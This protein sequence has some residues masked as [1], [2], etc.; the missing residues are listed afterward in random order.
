MCSTS[1][2]GAVSWSN[3]AALRRAHAAPV[4]RG[5]GLDHA[6]GDEWVV[7]CVA[8]LDSATASASSHWSAAG[9]KGALHAWDTNATGAPDRPASPGLRARGARV[10]PRGAAPRGPWPVR[11]TDNIRSSSAASM[12]EDSGWLPRGVRA[13][14]PAPLCSPQVGAFGT[15]HIGGP[16]EFLHR[17]PH[18]RRSD[19][20]PVAGAPAASRHPR[21]R[22][23][24]PDTR[25]EKGKGHEL[26]AGFRH[27][28]VRGSGAGS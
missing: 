21:N 8:A 25:T 6:A 19:T 9:P 24:G 10:G 20:R 16:A 5:E 22:S 14:P 13:A 23:R 2:S 18:C 15:R 28:P 1:I 26:Q 4:R 7:E 12:K 3:P 17:S 11:A 27:R